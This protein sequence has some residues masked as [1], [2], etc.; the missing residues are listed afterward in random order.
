[1]SLMYLGMPSLFLIK[2]VVIFRYNEGL[3]F[4]KS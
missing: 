2:V 1:M 4:V 3:S